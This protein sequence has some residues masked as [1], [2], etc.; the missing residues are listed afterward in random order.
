MGPAASA[1][2]AAFHSLCFQTHNS[3][4]Q[5]NL[6]PSQSSPQTSSAQKWLHKYSATARI[7]GT[8]SLSSASGDVDQSMRMASSGKDLTWAQNVIST[9]LST[10]KGQRGI[11][12]LRLPSPAQQQR[13]ASMGSWLVK[14]LEARKGNNG[15]LSKNDAGNGS[16]VDPQRKARLPTRGTL[17]PSESLSLVLNVRTAAKRRLSLAGDCC[18]R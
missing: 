10:S 17:I 3:V 12:K 6:Q 4:S 11:M 7:V 9:L 8:K 18:S 2:A 16:S 5:T 1:A 13:A 14:N 15:P